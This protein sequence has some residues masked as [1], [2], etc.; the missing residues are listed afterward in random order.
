MNFQRVKIR[1]KLREAI[2]NFF[3][4]PGDHSEQTLSSLAAVTERDRARCLTV[5]NFG[6]PLTFR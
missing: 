4:K 2:A 3:Q 6:Y 1:A 5:A